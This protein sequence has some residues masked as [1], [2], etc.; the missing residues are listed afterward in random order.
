[1]GFMC[2][3]AI[4]LDKNNLQKKKIEDSGGEFTQ[5]LSTES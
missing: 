3:S 1:M 2:S 5:K 4:C